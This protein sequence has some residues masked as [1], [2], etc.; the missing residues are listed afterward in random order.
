MST[1]SPKVVVF[2]S[3]T[4]SAGGTGFENLVRWSRVNPGSFEVVGVVS[5]NENGGVRQKADALSV[6][7]FLY[8]GD[9]DYSII[10]QNY[11]MNAEWVAL[12]GWLKMVKGLDPKK[13]FNIHPGL[14]S[15]LNGRL[16]GHGMW[17][18]R[19]LDATYEALKNGE[20]KEFGVSMHFVTDE[21]DR[22]PVFFEYRIPYI[23]GMSKESVD[24][25]VREAELKW[26]PM[27]TKM[28]VHGEISWD[29]H[30]PQSVQVPGGYTYLPKG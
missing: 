15:V 19:V 29:G 7:F 18:G 25:L 28:V 13:T 24:A 30:N 3:G 20:L 9:G 17:G 5:N 16:G 21:Y 14:L 22:G 11:R 23:S 4:K 26:Q 27:I 1:M 12:S 6:P 8:N 10:L 2:A